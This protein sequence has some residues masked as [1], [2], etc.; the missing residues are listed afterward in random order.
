[1]ARVEIAVESQSA[2]KNCEL[3]IR[4]LLEFNTD[5][6]LKVTKLLQQTS[7]QSV[8][9]HNQHAGRIQ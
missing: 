6:R 4:E 5:L 2:P 9:A 1:M 8:V 7:R 3:V